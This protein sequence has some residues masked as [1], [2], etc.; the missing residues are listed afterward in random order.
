M[1]KEKNTKH[2]SSILPRLWAAYIANRT[3]AVVGDLVKRLNLTHNKWRKTN[4][5]NLL[6]RITEKRLGG[7][8][9]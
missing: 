7:L 3:T 1:Q 6:I 9:T 2:M 4:S 8:A 5:R